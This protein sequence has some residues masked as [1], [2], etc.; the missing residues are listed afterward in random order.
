M[1]SAVIDAWTRN[2]SKDEIV[3]AAGPSNTA[4]DNL[5]DRIADIKGRDYRIGRLGE[6][7]SVFEPRRIRFSLTLA[8]IAHVFFRFWSCACIPESLIEGATLM[9]F[10]FPHPAKRPRRYPITRFS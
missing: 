9:A 10:T 2:I 6:G 4:T 8:F 7:S 5:L 3:I 1:S